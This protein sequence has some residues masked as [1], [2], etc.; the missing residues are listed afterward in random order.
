MRALQLES[1]KRHPLAPITTSHCGWNPTMRALADGPLQRVTLRCDRGD[2]PLVFNSL[3]R[4]AVA[5]A[6]TRSQTSR[7]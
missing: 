1:A 3:G 4:R 6:I 7:A 2:R 5:M